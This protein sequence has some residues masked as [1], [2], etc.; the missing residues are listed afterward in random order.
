MKYCKDITTINSN[1]FC[2]NKMKNKKSQTLPTVQN[3]FRNIIKKDKIATPST[4]IRDMCLFCRLYKQ[5][6]NF[7]ICITKYEC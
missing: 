2:R 4:H 3:P 6:V 7:N 1:K 5:Y